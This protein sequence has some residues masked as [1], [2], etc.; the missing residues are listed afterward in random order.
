MRK[1]KQIT[2]S[3]CLEQSLLD[4]VEWVR[5]EHEKAAGYLTRSAILRLLII[6]GIA[7]VRDHGLFGGER[8]TCAKP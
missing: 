3:F 8:A 5:E 7:S 4:D 2:C 6:R 1:E